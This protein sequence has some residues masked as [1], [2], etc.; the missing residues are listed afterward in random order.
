MPRRG[1]LSTLVVARELPLRVLGAVLAEA[2]LFVGNDSGVSHLAAASGT[3]TLALF[4]PTDPAQWSPVGRSVRCLRAA[5]LQALD[6]DT[7]EQRGAL[8]GRC[9]SGERTSIRLI[10]LAVS[11]TV[12]ALG[13]GKL[14][15]PPPSLECAEP[16]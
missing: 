8:A 15:T 10:R 9:V 12:R 14:V 2:G 5:D 11:L 7:V 3:P 1:P 4:G 16:P 6:V 13:P